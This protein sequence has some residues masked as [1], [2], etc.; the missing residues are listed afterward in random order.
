MV[1]TY[2]PPKGEV[3]ASVPSG[4]ASYS[5]SDVAAKLL[6]EKPCRKT[7]RE[8]RFGSRGSLAVDVEAGRWFDHEAGTGGGPVE[9][10]E[11]VLRCDWRTARE[12][13]D[14][15]A[16][17]QVTRRSTPAPAAEPDNRSEGGLR[18]WAEAVSL[19]GTPG[20]P[21][22]LGR[23]GTPPPDGA[24]VVRWHPNCPFTPGRGK[25]CL[26]ALVRNIFTG[27]PQAIQR[28]ALN[29]D[30][31]RAT[32]ADGRKLEKRALGPLA[33]G[34]I[35][36]CPDWSVESGLAI[37][38]GLETA[39]AAY[40]RWRHLPTWSLLS[41]G[42]VASLPPIPGVDLLRIYADADKAGRAATETVA[43]RWRK[44]GRWVE[45][46]EPTREGADFCELDGAK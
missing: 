43:T 34:A 3:R 1:E 33:G 39:L 37:A 9:L 46:F 6:G 5:I 2:K 26:V 40:H 25:P 35:M 17:P 45:V 7:A 12:W 23:C 16:A 41:S 20:E 15:R 4:P 8:W 21:Y 42:G 31:T 18:I 13:L 24:N 10:V 11:H 30:G 27:K 14:G 22:L 28:I 44:A 36:L 19:I 32:D 29:P 38:E